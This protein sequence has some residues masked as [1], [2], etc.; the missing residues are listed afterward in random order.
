[1]ISRT[2]TILL[3]AFAQLWCSCF[4]FY[5]PLRT[6]AK[7][8]SVQS[9]LLRSLDET[10][11]GTLE[12]MKSKYD[13]LINVVSP[14]AE[15]EAAKLKETVDKYSTY[16][17]IKKLMSKLKSMHKNEASERRKEKQLKSFIDL[18]KGKLQLEEILKEKLGL[19]N[20]KGD[21]VVQ[22]N[23]LLEFQKID[24]EV[25]DLEQKLKGVELVLPQGMSTREQR[26]Q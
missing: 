3:I 13:R 2:M 7:Y 6:E 25:A 9:T 17:E 23:L 8:Q 1:M 20:K 26:F 12:E 18:Y 24:S 15:E 19:Q 4:A 16:V 22:D 11:V 14:E 21:V 5:H 10:N